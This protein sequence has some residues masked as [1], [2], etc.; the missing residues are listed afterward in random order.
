MQEPIGYARYGTR[1]SL[2]GRIG[3]LPEKGEHPDRNDSEGNITAKPFPKSK[4]NSP[5]QTYISR[6]Q[7]GRLKPWLN[8]AL[9]RSFDCHPTAGMAA[10]WVPMIRLC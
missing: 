8:E 2:W 3:K 7:T 5:D 6:N 4:L 10:L 1:Q 9:T